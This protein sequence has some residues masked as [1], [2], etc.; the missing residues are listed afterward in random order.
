M[1]EQLV[2]LSDL[3]ARFSQFDQMAAILVR[4]QRDLAAIDAAN[5]DAA[6]RHDAVAVSYHRQVDTPTNDMMTLVASI[7]KVLGITGDNG[8]RVADAF[9]NAENIASQV[10]KSW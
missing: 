5:R 6:G 2:V 7:E 10:A 8:K 3:K 9:Y 1:P 4:I